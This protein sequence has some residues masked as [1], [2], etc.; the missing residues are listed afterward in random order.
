MKTFQVVV[1][2]TV[3]VEAGNA[4]DAYGIVDRQLVNSIS[5]EMSQSDLFESG[6]VEVS[7][8]ILQD[9]EGM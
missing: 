8:V 7:E 1:S 2:A 6:S 3:I 4:D 5:W 9:E